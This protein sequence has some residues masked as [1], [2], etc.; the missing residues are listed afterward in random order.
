[1]VATAKNLIGGR[2]MNVDMLKG[3]FTENRLKRA[4]VAEM[5]GINPSTLHRKLQDGRF[6]VEEAGILREK[7][8]L[9]NDDAIKIFLS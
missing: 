5:L 6:S 7:L 3:K 8:H 2:A 1:V 4:K 9:S